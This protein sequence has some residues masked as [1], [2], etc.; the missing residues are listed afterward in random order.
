[1]VQYLVNSTAAEH[2]EGNFHQKTC[3]KALKSGRGIVKLSPK[4]RSVSRSSL[5]KAFIKQRLPKLSKKIFT[6]ENALR[7]HQIHSGKSDGAP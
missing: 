2:G 7:C 5:W 1:M 6:F 4:P 3:V